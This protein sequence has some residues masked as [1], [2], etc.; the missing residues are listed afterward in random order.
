MM[1][2]IPKMTCDRCRKS[3]KTTSNRRVTGNIS[4]RGRSNESL[5]RD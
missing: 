5:N 1:I 2:R 4:G 3:V